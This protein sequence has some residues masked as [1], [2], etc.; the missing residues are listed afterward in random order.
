MLYKIKT[1]S[2]IEQ[3]QD[4]LPLP[5]IAEIKRVADIL[6]ENYNS[7]GVDGGYILVAENIADIENIKTQYIDYT[8]LIYE[9]QDDIGDWISTLYL[10]GTEYS[11]TI[12]T[13]KIF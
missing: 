7:Q 8:N 13:R 4:K 3:L 5:I 11:I 6:D 12:I 1:N 2:E 9:F 10:V